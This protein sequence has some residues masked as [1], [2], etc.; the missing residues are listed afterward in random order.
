MVKVE[1]ELDQDGIHPNDLGHKIIGNRVFEAIARNCTFV[2]SQM[3]KT[4]LQKK[5]R[6]QY[7]NGP[8]K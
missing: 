4:S 3:H 2:A 6:D 8:E 5:F 7:G 1:K